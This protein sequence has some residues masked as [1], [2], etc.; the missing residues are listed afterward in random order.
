MNPSIN[1]IPKNLFY[2]IVILFA[3]VNLVTLT[4]VIAKDISAENFTSETIPYQDISSG[5][6]Y[7]KNDTG[8]FP[9]LTQN[10][11]YQVN[12]NGLLARV[13][14]TQTFNNST[15]GFLEAVYVFPLI[16]DAAV[17]S[18]VME[19]GER[20][21]IGKIKK[22]QQA[23]KLYNKAKIQGKKTSLVTQQRPNLFTT[24]L[25]NIAPGETIKIS[26]SYLQS[27][28][29][30]DETFSLRIPLTLTPRF[31]PAPRQTAI[32][33]KEQ[34][35]T[36]NPLNTTKIDSHG[37]AIANAR[38]SDADE[39]TPF[40]MRVNGIE[41]QMQTVTLGINLQTGLPVAQV[42]SLYH[43]IKQQRVNKESINSQSINSQSINKPQQSESLTI[44]LAAKKI[45]LDQDFVLQWQLSQGNI[46]KAAFFTQ[47]VTDQSQDDYHYGLL[48]VMP[49]KAYNAKSLDKEVVYIIDKSGSMGGV[50]M[51]QAKQALETALDLLTDKD[52]FNIIAFDNETRSLFPQSKNANSSNKT[53]AKHWLSGLNASGG[54]NM[55]PAIEQA[56]RQSED[57]GNKTSYRQVV[58]ITDGS[59]GNEDELLRLIDR[60]LSNTRLHTIGIGSAP[61]GYFMTQAAKVG[62]GTYRYIGSINEVK[63]Q[64]TDLFNQISKPLMKNIKVIWP[65]SSVE[66]FPQQLPDLYAGEPLLISARW[67]KSTNQLAPQL[68]N[69]SGELAATTWQEQM[70][71]TE[72][73][74]QDNNAGKTMFDSSISQ[75][76]ARKKIDHLS[77][78]QRRSRTADES[79]ELK[80]DITRLALKHHLVSPYTSFIAIEEQ[81]SRKAD[82]P[83]ASKGIKNLMP[84]GSTQAVPLANTALG[85][86]GYFYLSV[87]LIMIALV[88]RLM[89]IKSVNKTC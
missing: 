8:F 27:V 62:R 83:L 40:Q 34:T 63:Q 37:W 6:L 89:T 48:M 73:E 1:L 78:L 76:W 20:R 7:F 23:L 31:I 46:P 9:A 18:M 50:A 17:D 77:L 22:K 5:S 14:F 44:T 10:S 33:A 36:S 86:A 75:W 58:F 79:S 16:D 39:I 56:L 70:I 26:I 12:V 51:R 3:L 53:W 72:G 13:N 69:I 82:T 24:K 85:L 4:Q 88:M 19:I 64:M 25:A 65:T 2:S 15:D 30:K 61:N 67:K 42:V 32:K 47:D 55:Y 28:A 49:P 57:N 54:T 52:S 21:I 81:V 68:I 38:V 45:L 74:K 29:L 66:M 80:S 41:E 35:N 59:V 11:D 60:D 43:P 87:L 71:I 84:K